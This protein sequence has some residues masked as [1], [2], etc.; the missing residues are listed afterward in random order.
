MFTYAAYGL[1]IHSEL[2]L[3]EFT[4][5]EVNRDV[6]VCLRSCD[7]RPLGA[8]N[9]HSCIDLDLEEALLHVERIGS[10]VVKQ[11]REIVVIPGSDADDSL[12]RLYIVG[13]VM[14]I[15][16]YQRGLTVMHASAVQINERALLL[17]GASGSGKSSLAASLYSR[18]H[19]L[20]ADDVSGVQVHGNS[21]LVVPGYPQLKLSLETAVSLGM[22]RWDLFPLHETEEKLGLRMERGFSTQPVK[23]RAIYVIGD[24]EVPGIDT[25]AP[26]EALVEMLRH[27]LPTRFSHPGDQSHFLGCVNLVRNTSSFR[28]KRP[29]SIHLLPQFA[30]RLEE[31]FVDLS[32]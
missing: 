23:L 12:I 10:F 5:A 2:A 28:L 17:L 20:I 26:Q 6:L 21:F 27:S 22:N 14:A 25:L 3:P 13:T 7:Q 4:P 24:K 30:R 9:R 29:S 11:G 15:L 19:A 32:S 16:L 18:G 8:D 31:H 1:G